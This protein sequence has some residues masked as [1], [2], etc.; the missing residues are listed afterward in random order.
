[1]ILLLHLFVF[2]VLFAPATMLGEFDF[3]LD[4]LAILAA[5]II[6]PLAGAAGELD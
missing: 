3:T 4:S 2:G 1:M 6:D 5:P